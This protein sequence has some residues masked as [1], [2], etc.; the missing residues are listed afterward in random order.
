MTDRLPTP[1]FS[2]RGVRQAYLIGSLILIAVYPLLPATGRSADFLVVSIAAVPAVVVGL[3]AIPPSRRLPWQLLLAALLVVSTANVIRLTSGG[4]TALPVSQI[5]DAAGNTLA[6]AAALALVV[7]QGS[8]GLGSII[9]ATTVALALGGVLWEVVLV[10]NLVVPYQAP[11]QKGNLF[12]VVFVLCGVLGALGRLARILKDP[13]PALWLLLAALGL[14]LAGNIVQAVQSAAGVRVTATMMFMG[15]YVAVGLFGLDPKAPQLADPRNVREKVELST[16]RLVFLWASVA[17]IPVVVGWRDLVGAD[18]DGLLLAVGGTAVAALVMVRVGGLSIARDRAEQ[19]L[20]YEAAHD[21]LTGL[22]NRR[23]FLDQLGRELTR[24][25][26]CVIFF[27]DLDDFKRI[28]DSFGHEAGDALLVEVG[29]RLRRCVRHHDVVSRFG[30]D[31]FLILLRDYT[32][33]DIS[34]VRDRI[35]DALS[36]SIR[37]PRQSVTIGASIGVATATDEADAETLIRRADRAMY[38]AKRDEPA[39][40][41]IRVVSVGPVHRHR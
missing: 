22:P 15:A 28:N 6:L 10:P 34:A 1:G 29:Q 24:S 4:G 35:A 14:A 12:V 38:E 27:C 5:L 30:G 40:S 23:E 39:T 41:G 16:A 21:P 7:R 36:R 17:A 2:G 37:L 9:D 13:E 32:P 31:E 18:V 11:V 33:A 3:L 19:A 8:S 25:S 26:R 20:R